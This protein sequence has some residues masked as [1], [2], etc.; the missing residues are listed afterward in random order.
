[1]PTRI[2]LDE[3][4]WLFAWKSE[5]LKLKSTAAPRSEGSE[6]YARAFRT[7]EDFMRHLGT[8]F[9]IS[10]FGPCSSWNDHPT[11]I[12]PSILHRHKTSI[13]SLIHSPIHRSSYLT[14]YTYLHPL[15]LPLFTKTTAIQ[16]K[17]PMI[18]LRDHEV[19]ISSVGSSREQSPSHVAQS[20]TPHVIPSQHFQLSTHLPAASLPLYPWTTWV[21]PHLP[22]AAQG[23]TLLA[24]RNITQFSPL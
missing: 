17:P 5:C 22:I 12:H 23:H 13:G 4:I 20:V 8:P 21:S 2:V 11:S 1:M 14:L 24:S 7:S 16:D 15:L 19:P 9:P 6:E 3:G 18:N 10:T